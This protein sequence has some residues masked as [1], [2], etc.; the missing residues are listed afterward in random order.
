MRPRIIRAE[1]I[2]IGVGNSED[3]Q[4]NNSW[5]DEKNYPP[6]LLARNKFVSDGTFIIHTREPK[7]IA[8]VKSFDTEEDANNYTSSIS[9][10]TNKAFIKDKIIV[11]AVIEFWDDIK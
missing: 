7:F 9:L 2:V 5:K 4:K 10:I 1:K 6:F 3:S 11:V 8:E